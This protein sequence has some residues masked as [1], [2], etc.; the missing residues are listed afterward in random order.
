MPAITPVYSVAK[1]YLAMAILQ[2]FKT[3]QRIGS[4]VTNLSDP[5]ANLTLKDILSHRSGLNDYY[6]WSDYRAAVDARETPW[7]TDEIVARA[8]VGEQGIFRY[9]NI[10]YLLLRLALE[11]HY[12]SSFFEILEKLIFRPLNIDAH[13]FAQPDDW[14]RCNHPSI[15]KHLRAYHPGWVYTGT[16]SAESTEAARGLALVMR[17]GLGADIALHLRETWPVPIPQPHP[18]APNAGYGLGVMTIGNPVEV[19]GHGGQGPGFNLFAATNAD[20]TRWHGE[21]QPTEGEDLELIQRCIT[22]V[23]R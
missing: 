18:M 23:G 3:D 13:P 2:S 16:F 14:N 22:R 1:P 7:P 15:D 21:A 5:V 12:R 20:G 19:V 9:S 4:L 8:E 10:G 11:D 6:Q 17:G